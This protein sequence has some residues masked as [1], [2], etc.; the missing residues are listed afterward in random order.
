LKGDC[1]TNN[2][3]YQRYGSSGISIEPLKDF[4]HLKLVSIP[5]SRDEKKQFLVAAIYSEH[6]WML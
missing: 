1:R 5:N 6:L 3:H 2:N 4:T